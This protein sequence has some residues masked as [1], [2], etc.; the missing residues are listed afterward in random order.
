MGESELTARF[1]EE[2]VGSQIPGDRRQHPPAV[3]A[4]PDRASDGAIERHERMG[5]AQNRVERPSDRDCN[6]REGEGEGRSEASRESLDSGAYLAPNSHVRLS[7]SDLSSCGST[8]L[9]M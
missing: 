2:V 8:G 5:L 3:P 4:Q 6:R 1:N 7:R 9:S